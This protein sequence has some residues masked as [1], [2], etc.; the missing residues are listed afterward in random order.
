M[1]FEDAM[2]F[3][4]MLFFAGIVALLGAGCSQTP[5]T[6]PSVM[7]ERCELCHASMPPADSATE[8]MVHYRHFD[9]TK[10]NRCDVCHLNYDTVSGWNHDSKHMDGM[11]EPSADTSQEQCRECHTYRECWSCH[12]A[13]PEES[14]TDRIIHSRHVDSLGYSC[15][16]CH[17][18]YD[19]GS[20]KVPPHHNNDIV[21]VKFGNNQ[22]G[23][24]A[25]YDRAAL[26]CYNVYCHGATLPGGR[27]SVRIGDNLPS[28]STRCSFC[29]PIDSLRRK[30]TT[31]SVEAHIKGDIFENCQNCHAGYQ[32]SGQ[33]LVDPVRHLNGKIDHI[34]QA[35]CDMCH[36]TSED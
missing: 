1:P 26:T 7:G 27:K 12:G 29:H 22:W 5:K 24:R 13:P 2:M 28:D 18:G 14:D 21:E 3:P 10:N 6:P 20:R 36:G 4:R 33:G 15:D 35:Q 17:R 34:S 19:F 31:H 9:W 30:G 32:I 8:L 11:L 23:D 25:W 16:S